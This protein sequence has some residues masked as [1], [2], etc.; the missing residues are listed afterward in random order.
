[1][2]GLP[3]KLS[4]KMQINLAMHD[5]SNMAHVER[6]SNIVLP[7]LWFEIVRI[8]YLYAVFLNEQ[9]HIRTKLR[10]N[11]TWFVRMRC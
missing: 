10:D 4:V 3:L 8:A 7:M 6:F 11:N 1:M 2:S 5:V 9:L